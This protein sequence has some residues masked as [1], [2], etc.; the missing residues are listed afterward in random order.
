MDQLLCGCSGFKHRKDDTLLLA[1]EFLLQLN[2]SFVGCYLS[3]EMLKLLSDR[4]FRYL[5]YYF[6][7]RDWDVVPAH[8]ID[9]LAE[10]VLLHELLLVHLRALKFLV[11]FVRLDI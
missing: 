3:T 10:G 1:V 11:L 9:R 7:Q 5:R 8:F 6:F 2:D 4:V